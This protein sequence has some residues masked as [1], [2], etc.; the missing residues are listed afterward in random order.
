MI[1]VAFESLSTKT[2]FEVET[3]LIQNFGPSTK[4]TWYLDQDYDLEDL[5]MTEH[6][7][8]LYKL[9]WVQ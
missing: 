3:W 1:A 8:L 2:Q 4:E 7:H 5:V 9:K 6:I